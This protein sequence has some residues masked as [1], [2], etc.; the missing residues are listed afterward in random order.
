M[1]AE[2][3]GKQVSVISAGDLQPVQCYVCTL[4]GEESVYKCE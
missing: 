4:S 2:L 3:A 1:R